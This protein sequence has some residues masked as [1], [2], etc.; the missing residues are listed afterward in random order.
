MLLSEPLF[1]LPLALTQVTSSS[2]SILIVSLFSSYES[3]S[4]KPIVQVN[5]FLKPPFLS[6][7]NFTSSLC[8]SSPRFK[9]LIKKSFF[10]FDRVQ[11][12]IGG[13][14][15]VTPH[16][17]GSTVH[18][19]NKNNSSESETNTEWSKSKC[20]LHKKIFDHIFCLNSICKATEII[21]KIYIL[22]FLA[23]LL[24]ICEFF[25]LHPIKSSINS[26]LF[27]YFFMKKMQRPL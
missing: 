22:L 7:S 9:S 26:Q 14:G 25:F 20:F 21:L 2:P 6:T 16:M 11:L 3:Y 15:H 10:Y 19:Q 1:S 17:R 8:T 18:N 13:R 23:L 27:I 12:A 4:F 5:F 24:I